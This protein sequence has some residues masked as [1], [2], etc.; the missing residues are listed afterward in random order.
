MF[1]Q[2]MPSKYFLS[3]DIQFWF[4]LFCKASTIPHIKLKELASPPLQHQNQEE[5]QKFQI[6]TQQSVTP[7]KMNEC[8]L[9]RY[10]FNRKK[11]S[12]NNQFAGDR[13]VFRGYAFMYSQLWVLFL[14]PQISYRSSSSLIV[15]PLMGPF[16]AV[17]DLET[18]K[19]HA[20][21]WSG[22]IMP[23]E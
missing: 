21:K 5:S 15:F 7:Q 20:W 8:F 10:H 14:P 9:K 2:K 17:G 4:W 22:F 13:F 12:S 6:C 19:R 1:K 11:S 23:W 16:V 18:T 3:E